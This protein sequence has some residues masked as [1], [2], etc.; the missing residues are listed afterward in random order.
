MFSFNTPYGAC[1]SCTGLGNIVKVDPDLVIP[2]KSRSINQ[3][4]ILAS[5]WSGTEEG[6]ISKMY[7]EGMAAHYG[8][9]LDTP[10]KD[11]PKDILNKI[12]YGTGGEKIKLTYDRKYAKGT[13]FARFEPYG[14]DSQ[15]FFRAER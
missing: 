15:A 1:P 4:A 6:S 14:I 8:F 3:G 11:L 13:Q 9:S 2:D 7:Y 12:L 10:V 5:G